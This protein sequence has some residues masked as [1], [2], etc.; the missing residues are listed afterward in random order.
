M[1]VSTRCLARM[2]AARANARAAGA[3]RGAPS[4]HLIP[5]RIRSSAVVLRKVL[6]T[7]ARRYGAGPGKIDRAAE[8]LILAAC[9]L[10][11]QGHGIAALES[12]VRATYLRVCRARRVV[13]Y[14]TGRLED[15][16]IVE[17]RHAGDKLVGLQGEPVLPRRAANLLSNRRKCIPRRKHVV[18]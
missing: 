17:R 14:A 12:D 11:A 7:A 1:R 3:G 2:R 8:P 4:A 13:E 15:R 16:N 9:E 18:Y 5:D 6:E 10:V